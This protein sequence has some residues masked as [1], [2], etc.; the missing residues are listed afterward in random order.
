MCA[1]CQAHHG[2]CH[3]NVY[4]PKQTLSP[5]CRFCHDCLFL[6]A[7]NALTRLLYRLYAPFLYEVAIATL[8]NCHTG[9]YY[10]YSIARMRYSH[11][12]AIGFSRVI[13][14]SLWRSS[15]CPTHRWPTLFTLPMD[16][17]QPTALKIWLL[18]RWRE[19]EPLPFYFHCPR[20]CMECFSEKMRLLPF[21]LLIAN[22]HFGWHGPWWIIAVL[23]SVGNVPSWKREKAIRRVVERQAQRPNYRSTSCWFS[24][25]LLVPPPL[26]FQALVP[27]LLRL[28]AL[29]PMVQCQPH[30][31]CH[32]LNCPRKF[33]L[34]PLWWLQNALDFTRAG[35]R[36]VQSTLLRSFLQHRRH[37]ITS[38]DVYPTDEV[39]QDTFYLKQTQL[40][41]LHQSINTVYGI[42]SL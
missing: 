11:Q 2:E 27:P 12:G 41:T 21:S 3:D 8:N 10:Y 39:E 38:A 14:F 15:G 18:H 1:Q 25:P 28:Q 35:H 30:R 36:I 40:T 23:S 13:W 42:S 16:H 31:I 37:T 22:G 32:F 29:V 19:A 24:P 33:R 6:D 26:R 9:H 34:R 7:I 20:M 17:V 5:E 4:Y